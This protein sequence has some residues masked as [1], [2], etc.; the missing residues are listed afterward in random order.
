[1]SYDNAGGGA[2]KRGRR[3]KI[4]V[5]CQNCQMDNGHK[6]ILFPP[7]KHTLSIPLTSFSFS[8]NRFLHLS[9]LP[10]L[11]TRG[12]GRTFA[13]VIDGAINTI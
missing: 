5:S 6:N 13:L 1:M 10:F 12:S 7:R 11:A 9:P 4:I 8:L 2:G 3:K